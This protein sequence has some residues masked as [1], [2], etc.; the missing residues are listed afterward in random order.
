MPK[1]CPK[2]FRD[3]V[4]RVA[5][6]REPGT[7]LK[8][9]VADFGISESCLTGWLEVADI[10][11]GI[12]PG[13]T[14]EEMVEN[15]E[16]GKRV[17]LLR[18]CRRGDRGGSDVPGARACAPT[19]LS[20]AGRPRVQCGVRRGAHRANALFDAHREDPEFGYRIAGLRS[21]RRRGGEGANA[22]HGG[23]VRTTAGGVRSARNVARV[24]V[25][26]LLYTMTTSRGISPRQDRTGGGS[27]TLQNIL[28][29]GFQQSSQHRL[30]EET[31]LPQHRRRRAESRRCGAHAANDAGDPSDGIGVG[32]ETGGR[33]HGDRPRVGGPRGDGKTD[34]RCPDHRRSSADAAVSQRLAVDARIAFAPTRHGFRC[35]EPDKLPRPRF[36]SIRHRGNPAADVSRS[37]RRLHPVTHARSPRWGLFFPSQ[38]GPSGPTTF[39]AAVRTSPLSLSCTY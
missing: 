14:G 25:P 7:L 27:L 32:D 3:D 10:E 1:L 30:A 29:I 16:L 31:R 19:L 8:Q 24:A 22:L 26:D 12:K 2:E 6:S 20:L 18:A 4:V 36:S 15:R 13:T 21:S 5:R 33:V 39:P 23:F 11:D 34:A 38:D 35:K 17:R 9:I 37:A 28:K